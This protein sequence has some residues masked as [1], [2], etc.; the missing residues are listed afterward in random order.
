M[1]GVYEPLYSADE[2]RAVEA[3]YPGYPDSVPELMERAGAAVAR[4][5]MRAYPRARRFGVVCGGGA[6]GG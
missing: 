2:M 1:S 6:N 4:E 3:R 5:A